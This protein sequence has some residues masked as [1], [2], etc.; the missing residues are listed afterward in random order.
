MV[1][2]EVHTPLFDIALRLQ[3]GSHLCLLPDVCRNRYNIGCSSDREFL[4][5]L[6]AS[7]ACR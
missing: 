2:W 3:C 5:I 1:H 6:R 7:Q 4:A